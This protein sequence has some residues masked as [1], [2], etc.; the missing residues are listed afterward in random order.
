[1]YETP[2][3]LTLFVLFIV[4]LVVFVWVSGHTLKSIECR[5]MADHMGVRYD[6]PWLPVRCYL[7][8]SDGRYVQEDVAIYLLND[9]FKGE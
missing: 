8:V 9:T 6:V 5:Q 4:M 3:I 2:I 7:E 1:V